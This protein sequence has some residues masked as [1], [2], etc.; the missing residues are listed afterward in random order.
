MDSANDRTAADIS[1]VQARGGSQQAIASSLVLDKETLYPGRPLTFAL[2]PEREA[3]KA[4]GEVVY[5][6]R[7]NI[8]GELHTFSIVEKRGAP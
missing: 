4:P 5:R 8:S 3:L 2:V 7:A 6:L 1:Q